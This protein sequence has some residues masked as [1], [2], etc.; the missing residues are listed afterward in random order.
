MGVLN[1]IEPKRVFHYFEEI[2]AVPRGSGDT[3]ALT[4]YLVQFAIDHD[5]DAIADEEGNVIIKKIASE[6]YEDSDVVILQGHM[7]MVCA[8]APGVKHNFE[9]DPISLVVEGDYIKAD[10]TTLGGDDGIAV[11]Y[12]LAILDDETLPHPPLECVFTIDE[13]IGLL[14]AK[15]LDPSFIDGRRM[16][17]ID[18]E[19]EGTL[20]AGCAGALTIITSIPVGRAVIK[21]MPV[22]VEIGG[23]KGGHSGNEINSGRINA[24]KLIGRYLY[25]LDRII[26]YSLCDISGGE[27]DNA[28]P[29]S[30]KAH[31][32]IDE[33]DLDEARK[34]TKEFANAIKKEYAGTDAGLNIKFESGHTHKVSVMDPDSQE[35]VI[36]FL[37]QIPDGVQHMSGVAKD[38]V[39]T[40]TNLGVMKSGQ[41]QFVTTSMIRSS[42]TSEKEYVANCIRNLTKYM[43]GSTQVSSTFKAWEYNAASPL[44]KVMT[45]VY[46]EMNGKKPAICVTHG[47]LECGVFCEK[48]DGL[49]AVSIGPDIEEIHTPNERLSIPSVK[50]TWDY[51]LKV[52]ASLK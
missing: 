29:A 35:N 47:C 15:A 43:D 8:A 22:L 31:F 5:F 40:S 52:L 7:D 3:Q 21:G 12:M 19:E 42:L 46:E 44:A 34:F 25:E 33:D 30:S 20:T 18:S 39:Q 41:T 50:R 36:T 2:S 23:L 4:E 13:E 10:G 37:M 49:D 45:E 11:A 27:K 38:A 14:G 28:I 9:R 32:V 17:N 6:G 24:N 16:I 26:A 48:L 51:L 1:D